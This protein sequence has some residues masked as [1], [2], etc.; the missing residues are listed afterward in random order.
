[1]IVQPQSK[2]VKFS[3][4]SSASNGDNTVI[5]AVTNKS[6]VPIFIILMAAA[7]VNVKFQDGASGTDLTGLMPLIANVGFSS[8][9]S[10]VGHFQ[11]SSGNLLNLNLSGAQQVSGWIVYILDGGNDQ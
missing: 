8:G 9:Y 2:D 10:P 6:I 1:M 3:K 4:I 5:S 11:T 7:T